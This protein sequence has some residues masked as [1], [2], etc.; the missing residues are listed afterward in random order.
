MGRN[1]EGWILWASLGKRSEPAWT[2]CSAR[3]NF[4]GRGSGSVADNLDARAVATG[5]YMRCLAEHR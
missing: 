5:F 4:S 3:R 1:W 2:L